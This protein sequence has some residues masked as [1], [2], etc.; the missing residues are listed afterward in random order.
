MYITIN[1]TDSQI[2]V[3]FAGSPSSQEIKGTYGAVSCEEV[4]STDSASA[5]GVGS[6]CQFVSALSLK[7]RLGSGSKYYILSGSSSDHRERVLYPAHKT[8]RLFVRGLHIPW[9]SFLTLALS[10]AAREVCRNG[11]TMKR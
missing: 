5:V 11:N 2:I 9:P 8:L 3:E 10:L 1:D 6:T 4:F 7:V